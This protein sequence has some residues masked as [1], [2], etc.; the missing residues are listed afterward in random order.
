[1]PLTEYQARLARLLSENR[2]EDSYLAGGAAILAEANTRRYSQDLDYFHDTAA[3]VAS[4]YESD[5]KTLAS[6]GYAVEPD[7]QQPGYIRAIVRN[8]GEATKVEW[9]Q[10]SSWR[11][12]PVM[13][14]EAFGYQLNGADFPPRSQAAI[15]SCFNE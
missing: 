7:I 12:M 13:R 9:A 2:S 11:F 3:R 8:G 4:A 10:D 1:M 14:S 6:H 15:N 5:Q